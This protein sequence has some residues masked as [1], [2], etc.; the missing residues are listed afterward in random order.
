MEGTVGRKEKIAGQLHGECRSALHAPA[1]LDIAI[2]RAYDPPHIHPGMPEEILVL[3]RDQRVAQ[4]LGIVVVGSH[5]PPL[6]C[7]R[8]DDASV[9]V[10][11]FGN[12]TGS[13]VFE[14]IDLR[15]VSGIHQQQSG[16]RTQERGGQHEQSQ[17]HASHEFP[18]RGLDRRLL[19]VGQIHGMPSGYQPTRFCRLSRGNGQR[20]KMA[21][22]LCLCAELP[23]RPAG[24]QKQNARHK[25]AR[26]QTL[27]N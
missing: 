14:I 9:V 12:R 6:Q 13:I 19:L 26:F 24:L 5:H 8:S 21:F 7:E 15:Q 1:G 16:R 18:P 22:S 25:D 20:R 11:E 10:V 17:H 23:S 3:G 27:D 4:Y 2:R